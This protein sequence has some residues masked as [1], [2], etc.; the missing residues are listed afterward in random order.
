MRDWPGQ[1]RRRDRDV[2]EP[3]AGVVSVHPYTAS[4]F[5]N[6]SFVFPLL[7]TIGALIAWAVTGSGELLG[8]TIFL[9]VVTGLMLPLVYLTWARTPTAIVLRES[10]IVSL[11]QGQAL[12]TLSWNQ[13]VAVT[14]KDTM[15]NVRWYI[16]A[17]DEDYISVEGEIAEIDQ[18]LADARRL[19][20]LRDAS[21]SETD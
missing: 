9:A 17:D 15:G 11:H 19:A 10:T 3:M 21:E 2:I 5:N 4:W 18:L 16:S 20:G 6:A 13:V 14:K 8:L 1:L 7:G 12:K